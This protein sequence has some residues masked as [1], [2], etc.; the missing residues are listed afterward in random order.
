M[1]VAKR[2]T[3]LDGVQGGTGDQRGIKGVRGEM[4]VAELRLAIERLSETRR[5]A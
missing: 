1:Q 2:N 4:A 3:F 5:R